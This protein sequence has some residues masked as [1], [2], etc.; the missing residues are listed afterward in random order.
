ML[1]CRKGEI[2]ERKGDH[3]GGTR[4]RKRSSVQARNK[5]AVTCLTEFL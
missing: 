2:I 3:R 5:Q 4:D 1:F